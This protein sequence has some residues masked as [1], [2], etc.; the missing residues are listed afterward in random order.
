M[1]VLACSLKCGGTCLEWAKLRRTNND[2]RCRLNTT[3]AILP[4]QIFFV[5]FL[6][7]WQNEVDQLQATVS[8]SAADGDGRVHLPSWKFPNVCAAEL[9]TQEL[10]DRHAFV[11]QSLLPLHPSALSLA[12]S[13]WC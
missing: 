2:R 12:F 7:R 11:G 8:D 9:D 10:L 13:C 5:P 6:I 4:C 3:L 1:C